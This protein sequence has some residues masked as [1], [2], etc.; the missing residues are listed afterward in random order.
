MKLRRGNGAQAAFFG[1]RATLA[2]DKGLELIE[3]LLDDVRG[4]DRQGGSVQLNS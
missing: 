1:D 4:N 2:G 3:Y